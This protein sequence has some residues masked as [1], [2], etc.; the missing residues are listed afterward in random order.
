MDGRIIIHQQWTISSSSVKGC[1]ILCLV[2][3]LVGQG[4]A[5]LTLGNLNNVV[6][7]HCLAGKGRTGVAIC[8]YLLYSGRFDNADEAMKYYAKKRFHGN[9]GGVTQPS[10]V[11]YVRYFAEILSRK[12][13]IHARFVNL[14]SIQMKTVPHFTGDSC[15]PCFTIQHVSTGETVIHLVYDIPESRS[16]TQIKVE[17]CSRHSLISDR[18]QLTGYPSPGLSC[19]WGIS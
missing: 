2:N 1:T 12:R 16:S 8:C 14:T 7:V 19:Y 11:R 17:P 5:E 10:Q 6:V 13:T 4:K 15:R 3:A 18:R 9:V